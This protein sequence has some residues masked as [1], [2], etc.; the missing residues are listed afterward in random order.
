MP[1]CLPVQTACDRSAIPATRCWLVS[2][3]GS[4][5]ATKRKSKETSLWHRLCAGLWQMC[6]GTGGYDHPSR[7]AL[8]CQLTHCSKRNVIIIDIC[9]SVIANDCMGI[10]SGPSLITPPNLKSHYSSISFATA[11]A[12]SFTHV[13]L[14]RIIDHRH[15]V[16]ATLPNLSMI[17][18]TLA[19]FC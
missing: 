12:K 5:G 13:P 11:S 9:I 4:I 14:A 6:R 16:I 1:I 2:T 17:A 8:P 19:K 3:Q 18:L 10:A 7:G 15:V